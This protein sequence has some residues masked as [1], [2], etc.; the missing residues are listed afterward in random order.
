MRIVSFAERAGKHALGQSSFSTNGR[1]SVL[2]SQACF[3]K[4]VFT[5]LLIVDL[6]T[7]TFSCSKQSIFSRTRRT[8]FSAKSSLLGLVADDAVSTGRGILSTGL[9]LQISK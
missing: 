4:P 5:S 9:A 2:F 7:T 1:K 6:A 3:H 8:K